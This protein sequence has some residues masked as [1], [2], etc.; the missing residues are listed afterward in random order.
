MPK[1]PGPFRSAAQLTYLATVQ[2]Q[3]PV[4]CRLVPLAVRGDERG[5]LIALEQSTGVPFPIARV[6]FIYD[7][8]EGVSRGFH[9]HRALRQLAVC[10][11]GSCTMV[12]DDGRDRFEVRLDSPE[13]GIE[14]GPMIW[15]EMHDFSPDCVVA[16]LADAP[17]DEADYIRDYSAFAE[18]ANLG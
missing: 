17:Y 6:Y 18:L 11:A 16:V 15:R 13:R 9:A 14:I 8:K 3:L 12:L 2:Q 10:V 4:G 7:T 1:T 5:S